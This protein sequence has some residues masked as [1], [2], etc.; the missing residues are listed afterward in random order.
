[1]LLP[2]K[3]FHDHTDKRFGMLKVLGFKGIQERNAMWACICDC[4]NAK[5]MKAS[6]LRRVKSCGCY[7]PR[8]KAPEGAAFNY[9]YRIYKNSAKARSLCFEIDEEKFKSLVLSTCTYCGAPPAKE[10]VYPPTVGRQF[11]YNGID[12]VDSALGYIEGNMVP[13]C[14]TCNRAKRQLSVDVFKDW[15]ERIYKH[16]FKAEGENDSA[17]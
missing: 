1:M 15:V 11:T 10:T 17:T 9:L 4:G 3:Q 6:N 5:V 13:C 2:N 7:H 16:N 12:R 14:E 8:E